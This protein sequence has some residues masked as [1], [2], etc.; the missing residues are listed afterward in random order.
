MEAAS[1]LSMFSGIGVTCFT[2]DRTYS[3]KV[4][5]TVKPL[6]LPWGHAADTMSEDLSY[7][8]RNKLRTLLDT[9]SALLTIQAGV[10]QPLD[11]DA[12]AQLDGGVLSVLANRD[13]NAD[14]LKYTYE[15]RVDVCI[16]REYGPHDH[17]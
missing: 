11:A 10:G 15:A 3:E 2:N 7:Y 9:L 1:W 13:D 6:Y 5:S 4:P 14:T 8:R 17:R 12:V 16:V